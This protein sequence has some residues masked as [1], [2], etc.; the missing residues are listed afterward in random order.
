MDLKGKVALFQ[1]H[2]TTVDIVDLATGEV[3]QKHEVECKIWNSASV[4][5]NIA[6]VAV[7]EPDHGVHLINL[8]SGKLLCK[9]ILPIGRFATTALSKDT[10]TLAVGTNKG[11]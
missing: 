8:E 9:F 11:T 10:L 5:R 1:L 6:A 7:Y 4:Q 3:V 2:E